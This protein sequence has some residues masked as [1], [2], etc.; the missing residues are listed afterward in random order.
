MPRVNVTTKNKAGKKIK[1]GR[2]GHE[3]APGEKYFH[4]SFRYG[5]KRVRC[6]AHPP[7][8]SELTQS[9]MSGA[10]GAIE[11]VE[12]AIASVRKG[13]S[14][15]ED[16]KAALES[17]ADEV[18]SVRDEYQDGFDNMPENFQGASTGDEIQEKIDGLEEFANTLRDVDFETEAPEGEKEEDEDATAKR[19]D[20]ACDAAESALGEFGL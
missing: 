13:A 2:C 11:D 14:S 3:I 1:C 15:L 4:F 18:E 6:L 7:R 10:Y 20:D 17:A 8:Q 12:D 9:K 16:L 19:T 5:G